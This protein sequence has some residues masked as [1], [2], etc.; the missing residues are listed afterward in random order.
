MNKNDKKTAPK[1]EEQKKAAAPAAE[2]KEAQKA[3]QKE[4]KKKEAPKAPPAFTPAKGDEGKGDSMVKALAENVKNHY[5][6]DANHRVQLLDLADRRFSRPDAMERLS[7]EFLTNINMIIDAGIAAELADE[8][9][10]GDGTFARVMQSSM[11]PQFRAVAAQIGITLPDT[12]ALEAL[13]PKEE[14]EKGNVVIATDKKNISKEAQEKIKK[15]HELKQEAPELDP[16]KVF[17]AGED[18][19]VKALQYKLIS[20]KGMGE[21]LVSIVDFMR[22]Y[23]MEEAH[24]AENT[25]DA[26]Q[27]FDNRTVGEWLNDA[28]SIVEPTLLFNGIGRGLCTTTSVFKSPVQA[29]IV[30]KKAIASAN[31]TDVWDDASIASAV[32]AIVCWIANNN[33]KKM[34]KEIESLDKKAKDYD[35]VVEKYNASIDHYKMIMSTIENPSYDIVENMVEDDPEK[36]TD[37]SKKLREY[38]QKFL[39]A[40]VKPGT[41]KN[42]ITNLQQYAGYVTGLFRTPGTADANYSLSNIT[43]LEL[44]EE[45]I[46]E[47]KEEVK[48]D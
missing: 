30:L 15:E 28:F 48:K 45:T 41:Y 26:M 3:E 16:K 10:Y 1:K 25:A 6:H 31:G 36:I 7:P 29:F 11:L 9:M 27:K 19:L 34:E 20:K 35:S 32:T 38:I 23:R 18:A 33:I 43:E 4:Q 13:T 12:K 14:L 24:H 47:K 2:K 21:V 46:E 44:V 22:E 40:D 42:M 37:N 5:A 39:Y 17:A 8:A